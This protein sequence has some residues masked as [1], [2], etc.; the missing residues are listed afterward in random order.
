MGN[1]RDKG[2]GWIISYVQYALE[3]FFHTVARNRDNV[4]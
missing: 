3:I 4:V 1:L 2:G